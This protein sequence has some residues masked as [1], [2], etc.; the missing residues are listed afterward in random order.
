GEKGAA[1]TGPTETT[2][3]PTPYEHPT[4]PNVKMWDL[5]G[6]GSRKFTSK[7]YIKEVHFEKYFFLIISSERFTENDL[8]SKIDNDLQEEENKEETLSEIRSDCKKNLKDLGNPPVFLI[9]SR[10]LS[11]FD[12]E[13]LVS[14]LNSELPEH[15]QYTLLQSVPVT[16]MATLEKK[17]DM[18]E[19]HIWAAAIVS[20]GI[21]AAPVP[22]LSFACDT[23]IV[24]SFFTMYYYG[25]GL[26][27]RSLKKLS[28]RVNKPKLMSWEKSPFL[29]KLLKAS[30]FRMGVSAAGGYLHSLLLG[31][32]NIAAA[33]IA[34]TMTR[35]ILKNG[36]KL[37]D[38][39]KIVLRETGLQNPSRCEEWRID[40]QY[41][42][43]R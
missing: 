19:K 3:E 25:F 23:V 32:G 21:A 6:V 35:V 12:F 17:V 22:G 5:P 1:K 29:K 39:K 33:A 42:E 30:V 28:E 11:A 34:F 31:L 36:L 24:I 20:G 18:F 7:T 38:E 2:T 13:K 8:I 15:K 26:D 43:Y 40:L 37:A 10:D 27:D 9:N 16:S 14:T 41:I 4:L